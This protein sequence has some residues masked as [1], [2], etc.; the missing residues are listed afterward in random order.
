MTLELLAALSTAAAV[1]LFGVT[2]ARRGRI[3]PTERRLRVLAE[4]PQQALRKGLSWDEVR[5]RGPSSL[6]V[7]RDWLLQSAWAQRMTVELEAAGLKLRTGEYLIIRFS[8]AIVAFM[9]MLLVGRGASVAF[10]LAIGAGL[11]GF[12]LPMFWVSMMR[13][14]RVAEITNQLPEATQ[15]IANALRAGFAFQHGVSMVADQM[16]PPVADE[17]TRMVVDMNVGSSVEDA[18][19][20]LLARCDTEEMNL[21]VTAVL[22]QRTSGGNLSEILDNVGEQLREKE[23]LVGEV[24][25][26]TAQ[27][28]F[29]GMVL[30]VWPIGLLALFS[31]INWSQTSLLFT[32]NAGLMLLGVGAVLQLTGFVVIRRILDVEI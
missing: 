8:L 11:L 14:R 12:M 16:Q 5:R 17:F 6:P 19:N 22:V 24:R 28:R 23:R 21:L 3:K 13:Q 1:L 2:L 7:L 26:M 29:S 20:G 25:T 9:L 30:T 4:Q 18:L 27:Q 32:T 31:L 10:L 15:M